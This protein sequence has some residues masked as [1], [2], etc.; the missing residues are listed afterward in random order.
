MIT[1]LILTF[2]LVKSPLVYKHGHVA[3]GKL[4][5]RSPSVQAA[6][7]AAQRQRKRQKREP[8]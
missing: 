2:Y 6:G 3:K 1:V 7:G 8:P 4:R 5:K